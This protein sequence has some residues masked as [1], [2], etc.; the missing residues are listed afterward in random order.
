M[1]PSPEF[2]V[3]LVGIALLGLFYSPIKSAL[4]DSWLF[5]MCAIA[6]VALLRLIGSVLAKARSANSRDA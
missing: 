6:Y 5:V 1:R 4:G 2:V 3:Y